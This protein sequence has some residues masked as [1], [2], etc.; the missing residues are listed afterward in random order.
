MLGDRSSFQTELSSYDRLPQTASDITVYRNAN[1]SGQLVMDF[2]IS[3]PDFVSFAA[4]KN[5]PIQPTTGAQFVFH[6]WAFHEGRPNERKEIG[7]GYY[8][9]QR[10]RN[11]GGITVAF[12]R[13]NRRAYI[14]SSS[15]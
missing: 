15:R 10:A 8:Y 14:E 5:W 9:S 4:K 2:K 6:A 12:D 1:V 11:G 7:E 13:K 3:E